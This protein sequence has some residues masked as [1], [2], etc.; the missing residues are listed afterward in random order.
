[1]FGYSSFVK[2]S[3]SALMTIVVTTSP[4]YCQDK[5]AQAAI[6][7]ILGNIE[8]IGLMD[9]QARKKVSSNFEQVEEAL[10]LVA[11][12]IDACATRSPNRWVALK[13]P[14]SLGSLPMENIETVVR[15]IND[16]QIPADAGEILIFVSF[17]TGSN[18]PSRPGWFE[19]Y[20]QN[21]EKRFAKRLSWYQ[22]GQSAVGFNSD[23]LWFP[24]TRERKLYVRSNKAVE[25]ENSGSE[26]LVLGYR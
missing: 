7:E 25:S 19:I 16:K 3:L 18:P 15:E 6:A 2:V 5:S 23:N 26:I 9:P 21:E 8:S 13:K 22:Y 24:L 4:T 17:Y 14:I 20:T 10:K 12:E 11:A 1:M